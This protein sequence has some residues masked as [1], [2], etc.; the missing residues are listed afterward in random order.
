MEHLFEEFPQTWCVRNSES[1]KPYLITYKAMKYPNNPFTFDSYR[2]Y[3]GI[4]RFGELDC[5]GVGSGC[6][7]LEIT[8]SQFIY[9][10]NKLTKPTDAPTNNYRGLE[11][12][13]VVE[14]NIFK[15]FNESGCYEWCEPAKTFIKPNNH[16][17]THHPIKRFRPIDGKICFSLKDVEMYWYDADAF[18]EFLA[19]QNTSR[20]ISTNNLKLGDKIPLTVLNEWIKKGNES[21]RKG[22]FGESTSLYMGASTRSPVILKSFSVLNNATVFHISLNENEDKNYAYKAEGFKAFMD[23]YLNNDIPIEPVKTQPAKY[24]TKMVFEANFRAA[25]DNSLAINGATGI[26]ENKKVLPNQ[27]VMLTT[28]NKQKTK[29]LIL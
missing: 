27:E 20:I 2:N 21:Y 22:E 10:I 9:L 1:V 8:E 28:K 12:G 11:V 5:W 3:Y 14:P 16:C 26:V 13:Y 7:P 24:D 23:N 17:G 25:K 15:Q 18:I 6:K 19:K 29:L 4:D